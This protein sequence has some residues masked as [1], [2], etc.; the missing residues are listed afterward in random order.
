VGFGHGIFI[1]RRKR[2]IV[3]TKTPIAVAIFNQMAGG[4]V[5]IFSQ[6]VMANKDMSYGLA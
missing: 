2:K 6:A 1:T 4:I 3:R 5:W